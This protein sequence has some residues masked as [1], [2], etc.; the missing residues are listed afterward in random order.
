MGLEKGGHIVL[1]IQCNIVILETPLCSYV[2]LMVPSV[3][4]VYGMADF[5]LFLQ[6]NRK[7]SQSTLGG[8]L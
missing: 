4:T 5:E 6:I 1:Y 7:H 3:S 2:A 8:I